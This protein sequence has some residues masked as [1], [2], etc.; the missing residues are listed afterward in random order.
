MENASK[1]LIMAAGVL[2]GILI[3][4]LAVY[5]FVDFGTTS[6]KINEQNAQ[7]KIV[8]F[9][10]Q[11]TSYIDKELTIYDVVTILGYAQ[12]NN[13]YYEETESEQIAVFLQTSSITNITNYSDIQKSNLIKKETLINGKLPVYKIKEE[14]IRYNDETG[15]VNYINFKQQ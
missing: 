1:A 8:Q 6:A 5:I 4:S 11:F 15:K 7:Q 12:E 13:K 3:I 10:S 9:N 14:N 2:I